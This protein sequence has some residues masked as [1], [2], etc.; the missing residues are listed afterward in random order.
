MMKL[1]AIA[2]AVVFALAGPVFGA[3]PPRNDVAAS[4]K[5]TT[6]VVTP[7][8][9]IVDAT[10]GVVAT[11]LTLPDGSQIV[12]YEVGEPEG[13]STEEEELPYLF[14]AIP[15][16]SDDPGYVWV[17]EDLNGIS[18]GITPMGPDGFA[19]KLGIGRDGRPVYGEPTPVP[20]G[21]RN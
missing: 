14:R 15:V 17:Y 8:G 10:G 2:L 12:F 18:W 7:G 3:V 13:A 1:A 4:D 6:E 19:Q 11:I 5:D 20:R 16:D 21:V 9:I